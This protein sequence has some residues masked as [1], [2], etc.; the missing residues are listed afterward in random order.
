MRKGS[1]PTVCPEVETKD[2]ISMN[3]KTPKVVTKREEWGVRVS[4]L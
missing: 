3:T 2:L 1:L 4:D